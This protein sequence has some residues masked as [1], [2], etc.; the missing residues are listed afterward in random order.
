MPGQPYERICLLANATR[1]TAPLET[2]RKMTKLV[3]RALAGAIGGPVVQLDLR[4][5]YLKHLQL[6]GSSQGTRAA[7]ARV[8]D[9][10]SSGTIKP[11]LAA[12]FPLSQFHRAQKQF[13]SKGFVGNIVVIPDRH[14]VDP[15]STM[16]PEHAGRVAATAQ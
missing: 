1:A 7:F 14:F 10:I 12:T 16:T 2:H 4:T 6:H 5:M 3:R 9:Y 15:I 8:L 11:V 13:M